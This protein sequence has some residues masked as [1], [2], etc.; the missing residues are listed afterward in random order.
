[1]KRCSCFLLND[2]QEQMKKKKKKDVGA[3]NILKK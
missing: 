1:M 2:H 3:E